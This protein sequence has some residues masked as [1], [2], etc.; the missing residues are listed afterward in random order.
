ME[1]AH[2]SEK[3][4]RARTPKCAK[5]L[6]TTLA[7]CRWVRCQHER[8]WAAAPLTRPGRAVVAVVPVAL[9]AQVV[10]RAIQEQ[11]IAYHRHYSDIIERCYP[12]SGIALDFSIE[13]ILTLT[14]DIAA[15]ASSK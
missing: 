11:L 2:R 1:A 14:N 15:T 3:N 6:V 4:W 9:A 10:W 5:I 7:C 13:D 8:S 12:Q